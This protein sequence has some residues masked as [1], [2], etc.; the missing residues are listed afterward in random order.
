MGRSLMYSCK[1]GF[2]L[3][4]TPGMKTVI[5]CN[6]HGRWS[7]EEDV[8]SPECRRKWKK[9]PPSHICFPVKLVLHEHLNLHLAYPGSPLEP[10]NHTRGQFLHLPPYPL[11]RLFWPNSDNSPPERGFSTSITLAL[12]LAQP[13]CASITKHGH[14]IRHVVKGEQGDSCPP[15]FYFYP[16]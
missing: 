16:K 14:H 9:S 5:F 6:S 10:W 1:E 7:N 2:I 8:D 12:H 3:V 13:H 15:K 4:T 11:L